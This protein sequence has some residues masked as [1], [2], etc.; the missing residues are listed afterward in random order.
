MVPKDLTLFMFMREKKPTFF[1][2]SY[3][4]KGVIR[5]CK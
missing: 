1:I 2:S 3:F 4:V 5:A